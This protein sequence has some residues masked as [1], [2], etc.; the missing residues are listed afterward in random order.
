MTMKKI[1]T[2]TLLLLAALPLSAQKKSSKE[3]NLRLPDGLEITDE[4]LDTVTLSKNRWINDYSMIGLQGGA[5]MGMVLWNPNYKQALKFTPYNVGVL[6]TRYGKMF[7]YMPYFGFQVGLFYGTEGY[8]FKEDKET[9]F[10]KTMNGAS[11]VLMTMVEMPMIAHCHV[12]F[13]KMKMMLN[14]GYFVGYRLSIERTGPNMENPIYAPYAHDFV[15]VPDFEHQMP[16][17]YRFD[18][19]IKAGLGFGFVFDPIEVHLMVNYKQSLQSLAHPDYRGEG[20]YYQFG[21]PMNFVVSAGVHYQITR[22]TGKT[23]KVLKAE[24]RE[25]VYNPQPE[26]NEN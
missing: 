3:D 2:Y 20:Y 12:D 13:W 26:Q 22:R 4:Y 8:K 9:G 15:T 16:K 24:A 6:Y 23:N 11:E 1:L 21:Y 7:G 18:Y 25:A 17:E 5:G 10:T 14:I 19:G